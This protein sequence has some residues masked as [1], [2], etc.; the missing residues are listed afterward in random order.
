MAYNGIRFAPLPAEA[1]A[2]I[3]PEAPL[4]G[5]APW[6]PPAMQV[7]CPK[8]GRA[9]GFSG[10]PPSFCSSCGT[11]L[12]VT[13][14]EAPTGPASEDPPVGFDPPP[15]ALG[16]FRLLRRLGKGG[17]GVVY[18]AEEIPSG[19]RVALKLIAPGFRASDIAV[20]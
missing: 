19:R 7:V 5:A 1:A 20:E 9:L 3:G 10:E 18:E 2:A 12:A 11:A 15:R 16:G 17:M 14:P 6:R 8:C 13:Q 4:N